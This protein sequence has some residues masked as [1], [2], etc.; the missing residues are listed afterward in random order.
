MMRNKSRAV[1]TSIFLLVLVL[2]P[3]KTSKAAVRQINYVPQE[4][5]EREFIDLWNQYRRENGLREI[6]THEVADRIGDLRI[7]EAAEVFSHDNVNGYPI[8]SENLAYGQNTAE[9]VL[10]AWKNS[11]KHNQNLL[12][13]SYWGAHAVKC[14]KREVIEDG[15]LVESKTFWLTL[16]TGH[17]KE[18]QERTLYTDPGLKVIK[19]KT[20]PRGEKLVVSH[21]QRG[22]EKCCKPTLT[23]NF[24]M[25]RNKTTD[26][27]TT[28]VLESAH[29]HRTVQ[30]ASPKIIKVGAHPTQRKYISQ[31]VNVR[32]TQGKKIGYLA[33]DEPIYGR[34]RGGYIEVVYKN[35]KAK[36]SKA[37]LNE[38]ISDYV[39]KGV[40]IRDAKGKKIGYLAKGSSVRG[41]DLGN[42]LEFVYK[43][44]KVRVSKTFLDHAH[45]QTYRSRGVNV[46]DLNNKKIG[47]LAKNKRI[48][49]FEAGNYIVFNFNNKMARIHK[50]FVF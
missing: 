46:R 39:S 42:Q 11:Y 14:I 30:K 9:K 22:I 47:Y 18:N 27:K 3:G 38:Y 1:L 26:K 5:L 35:Q 16:S 19:D 13:D 34:D 50:N 29:K 7:R 25:E 45:Y 20:L 10:D 28:Y 41:K 48:E 32:N 15:K 23:T 12:I 49:G 40:N 37:F 8:N 44:Q 24:D 31:G 21:G 43:G 33:K 17:I 6:V 36:I 2:I 4:H